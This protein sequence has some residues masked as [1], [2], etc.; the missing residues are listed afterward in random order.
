[1]PANIYP[2]LVRVYPAPGHETERGEAE[3]HTYWAVSVPG[4]A[5]TGT[6]TQWLTCTAK[7][8]L[9]TTKLPN[10]KLSG[11]AIG[12]GWIDPYAQYPEFATFAYDKKLIAK[13]SAV[14]V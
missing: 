12:N 7:G 11:L 9:E 4:E 2:T 10:F 6:P 3:D 5:C 1:M 8:V 14:S 13:G